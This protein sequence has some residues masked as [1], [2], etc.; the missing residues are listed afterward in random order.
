MRSLISTSEG[1][2]RQLTTSGSESNSLESIS[3]LE[4]IG[5]DVRLRSAK[6][7]VVSPVVAA[8]MVLADGAEWVREASGV[9]V[10]RSLEPEERRAVISSSSADSDAK[11]NAVGRGAW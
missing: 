5:L 8:A 2:K 1:D 10:T 9:A 7:G 4:E 11:S 6:S 3:V